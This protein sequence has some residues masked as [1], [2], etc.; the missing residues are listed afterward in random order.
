MNDS[1]EELY[2]NASFDYLD[3]DNT[4]DNEEINNESLE[5]TEEFLVNL[6]L[7]FYE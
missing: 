5:T 7:N 3:T 1:M 6:N 4:Y 2:K